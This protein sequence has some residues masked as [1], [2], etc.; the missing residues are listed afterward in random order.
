MFSRSERPSVGANTA[1]GAR[2]PLRRGGCAGKAYLTASRHGV[3]DRHGDREGVVPH[4]RWQ[5]SVSGA[6]TPDGKHAYVTNN[7][8][9]TACR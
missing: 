5:P 9:G 1:T 7:G 8:E 6:I 3:G 2:H 4:H